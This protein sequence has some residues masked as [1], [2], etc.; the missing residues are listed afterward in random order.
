MNCNNNGRTFIDFLTLVP[1]GT[2][3]DATY[4]IAL[5]HYCCGNRKVCINEALPI[6]ADLKFQV[7]GEPHSVGNGTFCCD[8]LC[9]GTCTYM[10]YR[11][12]CQC[13]QCPVTDNIY[14]TMCVPCSSAETPIIT[15]G[16]AVA[17]PTNVQPCCGVTNA[18]GINC[19]FNVAT[20][21][22]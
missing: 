17:S 21:E 4:Q 14:C 15:A 20:E 10:P 18:I 7:L 3:E 12:G 5:T 8:V 16:I 9:T 2:A 19:S 6:A 1:G 22:A 13:G 11:C